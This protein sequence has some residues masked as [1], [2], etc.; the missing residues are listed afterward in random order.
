MMK[1][2]SHVL[3]AVFTLAGCQQREN[4]RGALAPEAAR[5]QRSV[6]EWSCDTMDMYGLKGWPAAIRRC[7]DAD[8]FP[9]R[10][11]ISDMADTVVQVG[12]VWTVN[13]TQS[14][15]VFDSL[16]RVLSS[17]LGASTTQ[18]RSDDIV[19]RDIWHRPN[20]SSS[21][22]LHGS[23][24]IIIYAGALRQQLCTDE[25]PGSIADRASNK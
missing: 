4:A 15:A 21:L 14:T 8:S 6:S 1:R 16:R 3:Y 24:R 10:Y 17:S 2:M 18:C 5:L 11:V 13:P 25:E 12:E 9:A 20:W 7:H 19:V 22:S 23:K